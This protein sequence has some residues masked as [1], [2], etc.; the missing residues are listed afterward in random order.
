MILK[1]VEKKKAILA[2][3]LENFVEPGTSDHPFQNL[4]G[5]KQSEQTRAQLYNMFISVECVLLSPFR[6]QRV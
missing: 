6:P 5:S 3:E 2:H 4:V 1:P